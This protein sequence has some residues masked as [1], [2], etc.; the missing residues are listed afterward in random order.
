MLVLLIRN[1]LLKLLVTMY[2]VCSKSIANFE[3]PRVTYIRFKIFCGV[4]LVLTS[5]IYA[6]KFGHFECSV[7]FW[8]LFCLDVFWLVF[9]FCLF[10]EMD[11]KIIKFCVNSKI[12]C[13]DAFWMLTVAYGEATL[14]QSNIYRWSSVLRRPRRCVRRRACCTSEHV[15]NRQKHW[16]SKE[17]FSNDDS[18]IGQY[19]FLHFINVFVCCWNSKFAIFFEQTTYLFI[20]SRTTMNSDKMLTVKQ[21]QV[22][23]IVWKKKNLNHDTTR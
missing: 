8:Q 10:K 7:N 9:D 4:M 3:F 17:N 20:T 16:W 22:N 2:V 21:W 23:C 15:N 5:L 11:Q 18:T 12:K 13:V 19:Y 1:G 6:D 14:D